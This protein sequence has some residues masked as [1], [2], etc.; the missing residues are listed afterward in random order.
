[1][2]VVMMMVVV[3]RSKCGWRSNHRQEQKDSQDSLHRPNP[4][5]L[6][7]PWHTPKGVAPIV[8]MRLNQAHA[9]HV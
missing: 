2:V 6:S 1:M 4:T 7:A 3:M 5:M 8:A 9:S